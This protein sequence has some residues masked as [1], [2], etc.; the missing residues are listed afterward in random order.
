MVSVEYSGISSSI[1]LAGIPRY[2][3]VVSVFSIRSAHTDIDP[4]TSVLKTDE[5]RHEKE[6]CI[7]GKID[8]Y[9]DL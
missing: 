2:I 1:D 7:C 9:H 4:G 3:S 6:R 8:G 5:K